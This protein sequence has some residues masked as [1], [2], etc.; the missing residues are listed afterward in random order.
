MP[1]SPIKIESGFVL[2]NV[3]ATAL[4]LASDTKNLLGNSFK[5]E[6]EVMQWVNFAEDEAHSVAGCLKAKP[7]CPAAA[8]WARRV[9]QCL[10]A[11]VSTR[12]FL[13]GQRISLADIFVAVEMRPLFK[14]EKLC[15]RSEYRH[16]IRWANT[17]FHQPNFESFFGN[18][19]KSE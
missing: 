12:T 1:S 7:K 11:H 19:K 2:D 15:S 13:V 10:D 9:L 18:A 5:E 16:A 14:N 3:I 4:F 6:C 17:M 8:K